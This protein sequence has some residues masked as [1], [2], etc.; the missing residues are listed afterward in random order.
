[1]FPHPAQIHMS[2]PNPNV[3]IFG[4]EAF[5]RCLGHEYGAL[6]NGIHVLIKETPESSLIPPHP[7]HEDI[8]RKQQSMEQEAGSHQ[9]P[10]LPV[11]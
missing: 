10:N 1:M 9:T 7:P 4:G 3:M 2:K 6:M 11:P 5:G 8:E